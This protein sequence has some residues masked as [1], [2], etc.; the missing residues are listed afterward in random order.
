MRKKGYRTAGAIEILMPDNIFQMKEARDKNLISIEKGIAQAQQFA[1]QLVS[2]S[3]TWKKNWIFGYL[4]FSLYVFAWAMMS[5]AF[6]YVFGKLFFLNLDKKT[7]SR[8]N[9]CSKLC[10]VNNIVRSA[11]SRNEP[12][13]GKKC[14]FCM[15]C[16]AFCPKYAIYFGCRRTAKYHYHAVTSSEILRYYRKKST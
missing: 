1:Q 16:V 2:E 13:I 10:P 14:E 7:C 3:A 5:R 12:M 9:L 11:A 4:M 8:C 15:R 6:Q